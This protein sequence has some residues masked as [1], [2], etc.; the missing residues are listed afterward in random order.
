MS[1][2]EKIWLVEWTDSNTQSGWHD[3]APA[4]ASVVTVGFMTYDGRKPK[5]ERDARYITIAASLDEQEDAVMRFGS[6]TSIPAFA[7]RSMTELTPKRGS[8]TKV[9]PNDY[10]GRESAEPEN[11]S[12]D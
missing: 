1:E 6:S 2:R 3:V 10:R 4:P 5:N 8:G 12:A 7:I 11:E 9:E